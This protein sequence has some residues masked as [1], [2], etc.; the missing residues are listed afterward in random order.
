M[1]PVFVSRCLRVLLPCCLCW[2][3]QPA[4]KAQSKDSLNAALEQLNRTIQQAPLYDKAKQAEIDRIKTQLSAPAAADPVR[5]F[6]IYTELFEAYKVFKYDSTYS[7]AKRLQETAQQLNDPSRILFA[8]MKLCF[9]LLSSGMY[10]ETFDSLSQVQEHLLPDSSKAEYYSLM[11]RYYYDLSDFD[12]DAYY[13]PM[14]NQLGN[15]YIDSALALYPPDTYAYCYFKGLKELRSGNKPAAQEILQRQLESNKLTLHEIAI[16]ASTLA[17]LYIQNGDMDHAIFLLAKAAMAD[18]QSSTKETSAAF[19]IASLLNQKGDVK[20]AAI[21]V[22]Q[23]ITDALFYGA[24]Q[25]KVQV[26]AVLP[27][28]EAEKLNIVEKSRTKLVWYAGTVTF[29]LL[30]V[31]ASAVIILKQFNKLKAAQRTIV[32]AHNQQQETNR[33]LA[34]I[35]EKLQEAN[36]IKEEYIGYFFNVN[37][38][39]YDKIERLKKSIEQKL[40]DRK[41]EEI[42]YLV[43]NINLKKEKDELLK[44]FDQAFLKLFPNFLHSFNTLFKEEDRVKLKDDE[45]LNTDLRI[46]ALIR[47]GIHDN[48]KIAHILQ[49]SVNTINTYK[50]KIKNKSIVPNEEFERYI[51]QQSAGEML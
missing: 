11:G 34:E 47:M 21:Y 32:Q 7:Y 51:M 40:A 2:F 35:N 45:L 9:S 31:I 50:T 49:Y 28:I 29:L 24:R 18:V 41:T 17:D 46:F 16:T 36:R 37:A 38:E 30:L 44:N 23:A 26:S 14:Y 5:R 13:T 6:A 43:S 20:N 8:R 15:R 3:I 22:D 42:R 10:K 27:M 33:H 48:E 12:K 1:L 25:R 4:G 19:I 39:F